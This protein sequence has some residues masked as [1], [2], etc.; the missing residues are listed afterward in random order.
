SGGGDAGHSELKLQ[1]D[2]A[3]T[4][5]G[6][7]KLSRLHGDWTQ[8]FTNPMPAEVRLDWEL[9]D[10]D[11]PWGKIPAARF[12]GRTLRS[13]VDAGLL[14]TELALDSGVLQ[15]KWFQL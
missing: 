8:S 2:D 15:S 10:V 12:T 6:Q 11:T 1:M 7:A 4:P 5:W 13:E 14:K 9:T 3:R